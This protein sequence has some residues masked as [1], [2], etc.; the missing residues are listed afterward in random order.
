MNILLILV[1]CSLILG[2]GALVAF[3]WTLRSRQYDDLDGEA[4]R[5]LLD[6]GRDTADR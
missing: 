5:I 6:E 3:V 4:A 2:M 1:P